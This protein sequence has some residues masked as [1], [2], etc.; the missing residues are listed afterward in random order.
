[1]LVNT[2]T[3]NLNNTLERMGQLQT[4]MSSEH[5]KYAHISD[6]PISLI[7]SQQARAKLRQVADYQENVKTAQ[8]WMVS[9]ETGFDE[10]NEL[11][12]EALDGVIQGAND[13]LTPYDRTNIAAKVKQLRDQMLSTLNMTQG[14]KYIYGG[15]NTLGHLDA[16]GKSVAPFEFNAATGAFTYNGDSLATAVAAPYANDVVTIDVGVSAQMPLSFNGTRVAIYG[17]DSA[18]APKTLIGLFDDL[19]NSLNNTNS[20]ASDINKY[21]GELQQAQEHVLSMTSDIGGRTNRLDLLENR[22]DSDEINYIEMKSNAEDADEAEL[23]MKYKM[24]E[25]VYKAALSSGSYIIQPTLM[26]YLR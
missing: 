23:I 3:G 17:Y 24:A 8:S 15:Y 13:T 2:F 25:T 9:V 26:D 12:K 14:D 22:Y 16:S 5:S 10:M 20:S 1:M 6:D 4:Q 21:I 18:G 19:Y 7:Y 11:I